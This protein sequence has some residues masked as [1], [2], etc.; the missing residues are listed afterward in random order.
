MPMQR[1]PHTPARQHDSNNP[2]IDSYMVDTTQPQA[3][4]STAGATEV[5]SGEMHRGHLRWQAAAKDMIGSLATINAWET[6]YRT[7]LRELEACEANFNS[8]LL[9]MQS[10]VVLQ[11]MFC[12]WL[13]GQLAAQ[14]EK[15]KKR[16]KGQLNGDGLPRLLT[17]D[18]FYGLVVEHEETS[19]IEKVTHKARKK[20]RDERA[21]LMEAWKE[22]DKKQLERNNYHQE[23][24]H[25]KLGL[26]TAECARVKVEKRQPGWTR[27]KLGK[28]ESPIPKPV[29]DSTDGDEAEGDNGEVDDENNGNNEDDAQDNESDG[30]SIKE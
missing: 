8:A 13:S 26:W 6:A 3:S 10:T 23:A 9:G 17:G 22:A 27:P 24:Y 11:G 19:A 30:G 20:L 28:L 14:E 4:S 29:A 2:F 21:G 1:Q 7:A 25:H 18:A 15:Q 12:E 5:E 16:K